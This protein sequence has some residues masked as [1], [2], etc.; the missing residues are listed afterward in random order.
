M[1]SPVDV[2]TWAERE[3][4]DANGKEIGHAEDIY[5]DDRSGEPA[6]LLVRGGLFGTRMHF[7]PLVGARIEDDRIRV[8]WDYDTIKS[9]PHVSADEH[10]SED[11][12]KRLFDHYGLDRG[13]A[14]ATILVLRRMV[15]V[16]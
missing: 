6:F 16:G 8:A 4:V 1:P 11:E 10:L 2:R 14:P 3:V 9:A 13:E 15:I 5:M 7:V 12:E